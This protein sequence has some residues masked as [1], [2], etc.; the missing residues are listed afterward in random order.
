MPKSRNNPSI[1]VIGY[2]KS[3]NTWLS[4]LC[5]YCF[6]LPYRNFGK[7]AKKPAQAW[8]RDSVSGNHNWDSLEGYEYVQKTHKPPRSVPYENGIIFYIIR[9]PR[10]AFVSYRHFMKTRLAGWKGRFR[11]ILLG[12]LGQEAQIKWFLTKWERHIKNWTPYAQAVLSYDRILGEG[13]SY[14]SGVFENAGCK[15]HSNIVE[16]AYRLFSFERMSGGRNRGDEDKNSFF[17]RGISGDWEN[18]LS[19]EESKAFEKAMEGVKKMNSIKINE[20]FSTEI[21][22]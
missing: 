9:D 7:P 8:I 22:K 3:G 10:D 16:E 1:W 2:P 5:S 15:I 4:Y 6:N 20:V 17:R 13:V 19:E 14:L 11:F 12:M 18:H 21:D